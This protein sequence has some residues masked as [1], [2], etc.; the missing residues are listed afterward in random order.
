MHQHED[1]GV[2]NRQ[3]PKRGCLVALPSDLS[4]LMSSSGY[5]NAQIH[6]RERTQLFSNAA[7]YNPA[8]AMRASSSGLAFHPP[9]KQQYSDD[10]LRQL[11]SQND[12][13]ISGLTAKVQILK[14][15]SHRI[16]DEVR[17][18]TTL[19]AGME[20]KFE[21]ARSHVKLTVH[22]L[23]HTIKNSGVGWRAW[24]GLF[25]IILA[26]FWFVLIF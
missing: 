15:I 4:V 19:L 25:A 12:E 3:Q 6:Q 8:V 16:G 2:Y 14:N 20:N 13:H 7:P 9:A 1:R 22:K 21:S 5:S 18:S 23:T 24:L 17:E 11:E 26:C 10:V